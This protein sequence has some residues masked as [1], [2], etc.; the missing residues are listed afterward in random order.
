MHAAPGSIEWIV[1]ALIGLVCLALPLVGFIVLL[2]SHLRLHGS[3]R[4]LHKK[5]DALA[6]RKE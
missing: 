3:L 2:I 4:E 1:I 5:L 6:G